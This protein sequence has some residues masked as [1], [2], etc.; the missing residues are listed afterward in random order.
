MVHIFDT[1]L[2][3]LIYQ[4]SQPLSRILTNQ[5]PADLL[6]RIM[7]AVNMSALHHSHTR[8]HS[9]AFS[10]FQALRRYLAVKHRQMSNR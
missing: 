10:G 6:P 9:C 8:R 1:T 4:H 3:S 5:Q 7:I 2:Y